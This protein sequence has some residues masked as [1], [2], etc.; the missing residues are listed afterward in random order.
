MVERWNTRAPDP[1]VLSARGNVSNALNL[2]GQ[3]R[4]GSNIPAQELWDA[5]EYVDKAIAALPRPA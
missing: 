2:V 3:I 1:Q 5:C 4:Q